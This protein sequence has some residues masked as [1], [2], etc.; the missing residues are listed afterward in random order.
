M[1]IV[2]GL[3][4][5]SSSSERILR[6]FNPAGFSAGGLTGTFDR[7]TNSFALTRTPERVQAL[8]GLV[9]GFNKQAEVFRGLRGQ[10]APGLSRLTTDITDTLGASLR[11]RIASIR[12]EGRRTVGNIRE[13]LARRR[14]AG[15][16]FQASEVASA[17]AEFSRIED[18]ARAENAQQQA[19]A[20]AAA[21]LQEI[22]FSRDLIQREFQSSIAGA[23]AVLTDLN[24][25]TAVAA[26]LS[27]LSSKLMNDNLT[28]QAEARAAQ[29]QAGEDFLGSIMAM[30][31]GGIG[32][33]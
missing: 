10:V 18:A 22:D 31:G 11:E 15:S 3:L 29:E 19:Q 33:G 9:S 6:K 7:S 21:F 13:N 28:A 27:G 1:R 8:E 17:E 14:L 25:D 4:G 2:K 12:G 5:G 30:F 20:K 32:G 24:F 16:S 26:E 23:Q